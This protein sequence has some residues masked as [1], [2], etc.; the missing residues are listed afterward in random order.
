MSHGHV[1]GFCHASP[2]TGCEKRSELRG[3]WLLYVLCGVTVCV[4]PRLSRSV[5][6]SL[7]V[8]TRSCSLF[9]SLFLSPSHACAIR[10]V[11]QTSAKR[12]KQCQTTN[13]TRIQ[14]LSTT[15]LRNN[16]VG[17]TK[18]CVRGVGGWWV[19]PQM[20]CACFAPG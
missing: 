14:T 16:S 7:S 19:R 4:S 1:R 5:S 9:L 10:V 11:C 18:V 8:R 17:A 15:S 2:L 20:T 13:G 12:N 6:L 3:A